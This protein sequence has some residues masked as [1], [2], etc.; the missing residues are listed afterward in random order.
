MEDHKLSLFTGDPAHVHALR[1]RVLTRAAALEAKIPNEERRNAAANAIRLD[2]LYS[3]V[4]PEI[5]ARLADMPSDNSTKTFEDVYNYLKETICNVN[6]TELALN[7]TTR[8]VS[9]IRNPPSSGRAAKEIIDKFCSDFRRINGDLDI[10]TIDNGTMASSLLIGLIGDHSLR[11]QLA[12]C[13]LD[14]KQTSSLVCSATAFNKAYS[15]DASASRPFSIGAI[16]HN[17]RCD[18][19]GVSH[20]GPG[21]RIERWAIAGTIDPCKYCGETTHLGRNCE[22]YFKYG[23]G[24]KQSRPS[25]KCVE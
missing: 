15:T 9:A 16:D 5:Q 25:T 24:N 8:L 3:L 11:L 13:N 6:N 23:A 1:E 10:R 18:Y 20:R 14:W 12:S 17:S 21:C 4:S 2:V 7:A 19:C 22:E